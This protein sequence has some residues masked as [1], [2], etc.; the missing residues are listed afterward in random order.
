VSDATPVVTVFLRHRGEVL[1]LRRADAAGTYPGCWGGVSGYVEDSE[2]PET[3]AR[4]EITEETGLAAGEGAD[5]APVHR[6]RS[7]RPFTVDDAEGTFRVHPFLFDAETRDVVTNAETSEVTWIHPTDLL[8][9][10]T[11]TD[12]WH[13]Y[14]SV[15][16][17][18]KSV[19]ADSD[20]GAAYLSVRA[21][22]VLRDRAGLLVAE[23]STPVA[24]W[25][26]LTDL[27]RRLRSARPSMAVLEN[28]VDRVVAEAA[29]VTDRGDETDHEPRSAAAVERAAID[30]I[31][32]AIEA[33]E[34]TAAAAAERIAG[35]TVLTLSRSSTLLAAF[36]GAAA[37]E[38]PP[39]HLIVAES[40][41]A[42]EGVAVAEA[43]AADCPVTLTTDAAIGHV[44]A[45]LDVDRVVVGADSLLPDGRV[46]NKTG[47]RTLAVVA[48][49]AG[50]PVDV[51]A[52]S[53]KLR[54]DEG[55]TLE[56]GTPSAVYD[57]D[58]PID[59]LN[60]TFDVTP[61]DA[62]TAVVTERG[63]LDPDELAE[64]TSERADRTTWS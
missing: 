42:R 61:A 6:V 18:V 11:V 7:G 21:L 2:D 25:D 47:T 55:Y 22:E 8:R 20:H 3:T 49:R 41:P 17:T 15:A 57:G 54:T 28:R 5:D 31:E 64:L 62:V 60:P 39:E 63:V 16:P 35:Q 30:A 48:D 59:V 32:A 34:A 45:E 4:R 23:K 46:I 44:L 58:A 37:G 38:E 27:A 24:A 1:A 14:E 10:E 50:V 52:A 26:E 19:V 12:L 53:D 29:G 40:R 13:A 36:E 56:S 51:V 43:L 9:R 33:D